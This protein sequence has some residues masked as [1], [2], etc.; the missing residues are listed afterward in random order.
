MSNKYGII[1]QA[2]M[3]SKRLY[4]KSIKK[5]RNIPIL[6]RI[7]RSIK[8]N[9]FFKN[10][11]IV[12]ATTILS[13]DEKIINVARKENIR[14]FRG[15]EKNVLERY[16]KCSKIN[17]FQNIIRLTSDNP[18][19]DVKFLKNLVEA[20]LK[21]NNDYTS[22]KLNLPIGIGAEIMTFKALKISNALS[23]KKDEKEHVCDYILKNPKK[24]RIQNLNFKYKSSKIKKLRLTVDTQKDLDFCRKF[25]VH[26]LKKI[27]NKIQ[28]DN[29]SN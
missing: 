14:F 5:I 26:R 28:Y 23:K 6:L 19:V 25:F 1:I 15:N 21:N 24:F 29:N 4:G 3:G 12:V 13:D 11:K 2:R 8:R 18:F 22:S 9:Q 7:I 20:H 27:R 17:K 16:Y 10:T